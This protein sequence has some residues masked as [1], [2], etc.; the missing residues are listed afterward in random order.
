LSI[1]ENPQWFSGKF[2]FLYASD[3]YQIKSVFDFGNINRFRTKILGIAFRKMEAEVGLGLGLS[4]GFGEKQPFLTHTTIWYTKEENIFLLNYKVSG[5]NFVRESILKAE[6]YNKINK[7]TDAAIGFT[8]N[9]EEENTNVSF[10]LRYRH[11]PNFTLKTRVD[12]NLDL[13]AVFEIL[14]AKNLQLVIVSAYDLVEHQLSTQG[15]RIREVPY[16]P[17][18][19]K[20]AFGEI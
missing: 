3:K 2:K 10:G 5:N 12:S 14:L 20:I 16:L 18:G 11:S 15:K 13:R 19:L 4:A 1:H 7:K 17:F 9:F 8:R 6:M